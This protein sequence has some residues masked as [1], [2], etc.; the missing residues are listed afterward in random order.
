ML[1]LFLLRW[2]YT[3]DSSSSKYVVA[4]RKVM[5]LGGAVTILLTVAGLAF[6]WW[7]DIKTTRR[8]ASKRR[9]VADHNVLPDPQP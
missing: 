9:E 5:A 7:R 3:Y 1:E 6:L 2:C 4:A 8:E